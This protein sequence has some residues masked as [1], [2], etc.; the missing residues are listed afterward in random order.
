[1]RTSGIV[2]VRCLGRSRNAKGWRQ[3]GD[4]DESAHYVGAGALG[5]PGIIILFPIL[6]PEIYT[7][8]AAGQ[9]R[10]LFAS[11]P[12]LRSPSD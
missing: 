12:G 5:S 7:S 2:R 11:R 8:G 4:L 9:R 1:M 6:P 3:R 10:K